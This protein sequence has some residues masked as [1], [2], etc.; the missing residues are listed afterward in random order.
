VPEGDNR[1]LREILEAAWKSSG[2]K[3][4]QL[5]IKPP[6]DGLDYLIGLF[7]ECKRSA[8][9]IAWS[10][11]ESWL[12]MTG[13]SL[14]PGEVQALMQLDNVHVRVMREPVSEEEASAVM[15]HEVKARLRAAL[16]AAS[17]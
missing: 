11:M 9:P 10:E 13:R 2:K 17:K 15:K 4:A 1:S 12:R 8:E 3:P 7:W 16:R 5:D 6:P 14:E